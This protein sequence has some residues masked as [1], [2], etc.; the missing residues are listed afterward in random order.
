MVLDGID[1]VGYR[2]RASGLQ[3]WFWKA[4]QAELKYAI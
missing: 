3:A 1:L 2:F 4:W